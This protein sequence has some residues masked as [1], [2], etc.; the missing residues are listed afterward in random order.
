MDD[1]RQTLKARLFLFIFLVGLLTLMMSR[2][3][4][5]PAGAQNNLPPLTLVKNA[6]LLEDW[7]RLTVDEP[8]WTGAVWL[9]TKQQVQDG[10]TLTF[11]WQIV[12]ARAVGGDGFAFVIQNTSDVALGAGASSIGYSGIANSI[13][14]E[15]DTTQNPPEEF[16]GMPGDPN[17]NHLSVQSR[18]TFPNSADPTYSLGTTTTTNQATSGFSWI[19]WMSQF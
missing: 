7:V 2:N 3:E 1:R 9:P 8:Q 11:D 16:G 14:V 4:I 6:I 17:A 15:F 19:I 10:F 12:R 5:Q 18:G 13:A